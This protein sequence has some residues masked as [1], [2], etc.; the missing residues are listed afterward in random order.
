[1]NIDWVDDKD[2]AKSFAKPKYAQNKAMANSTVKSLFNV[3]LAGNKV[4]AKENEYT[5]KRDKQP[6]IVG[7][8]N[9][10]GQ[11][12]SF[13]IIPQAGSPLQ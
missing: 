7:K 5:F 12:Y 9:M 10:K 8:I 1:M 13:S 3:N 11:F 2:F 6:T 4:S